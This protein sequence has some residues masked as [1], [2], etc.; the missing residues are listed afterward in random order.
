MEAKFVKISNLIVNVNDILSIRTHGQSLLIECT[1]TTHR[2][3]F[4]SEV[5]VDEE[6]NRIYNIIK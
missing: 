1:N 4:A 3:Y 6:L 2:I 5:S